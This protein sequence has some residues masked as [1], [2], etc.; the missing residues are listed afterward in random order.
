MSR[1]TF[2]SEMSDPLKTCAVALAALSLTTLLCCSSNAEVANGIEL[3]C[4]T[5]AQCP[6][7]RVCTSANRCL[8][9][10]AALL[11]LIGVEPFESNALRVSFDEAIQ[12]VPT[13]S[14]FLI[15]F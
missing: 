7:G 3:A 8:P 6:E 9:N 10:D 4:E 12:S 13:R 1:A 14:N 15:N 11:T 2:C 5:D